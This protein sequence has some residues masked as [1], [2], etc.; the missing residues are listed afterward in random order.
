MISKPEELYKEAKKSSKLFTLTR[1][2]S[3]AKKL[4]NR[5]FTTVSRGS[6]KRR[7]QKKGKIMNFAE[8]WERAKQDVIR[9]K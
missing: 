5:K 3:K 7:T 4:E 9:R 6:G 8:S 1:E 2:S